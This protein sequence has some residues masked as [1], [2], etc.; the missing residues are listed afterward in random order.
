MLQAVVIVVVALTV[1]GGSKQ[2]LGWWQR[3][4]VLRSLDPDRVRRM[5]RG[6]SARAIV[7]GVKQW[8]GLDA[9]RRTGLRADL[10]LTDERFLLATDRGVFLDLTAAGDGPLTSVR[11]TG[12]GRLVIEGD[13]GRDDARFR[14]E[15]TVGD[16]Q[17]WA[18]ELAPF[19]RAGA[20]PFASFG[21]G[22]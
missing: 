21:K 13:I 14:F 11:C 22:R 19:V 1:L 15:I 20:V 6:V 18:A 4:K 3:E 7:A 10:L 2:L 8:R 9:R 16:A 17:G 5:D 12:P